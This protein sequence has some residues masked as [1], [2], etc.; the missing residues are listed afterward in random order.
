[1]RRLNQLV[2]EKAARGRKQGPVWRWDDTRQVLLVQRRDPLPGLKQASVNDG[3]ERRD[4][5]R[6]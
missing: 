2:E 1:M 5:Q 3:L 6:L 4:T